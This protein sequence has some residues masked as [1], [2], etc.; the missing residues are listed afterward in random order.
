MLAQIKQLKAA[1]AQ[2]E[3][4]RAG[5]VRERS[6]LQGKL[7]TAQA[8]RAKLVG[9]RAKLQTGRNELTKARAKLVT[10]R[11][12][13]TKAR[14]EL[15]TGREELT[16]ARAELAAGREEL[17]AK[18]AELETTRTQMTEL[19]DGVPAAF[20]QAKANYL[21]EIDERAPRIEATFQSGLNG[22]FR[23]L[24]ILFAGACALT[25]GALLFVGRGP[26]QSTQP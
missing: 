20:E 8:Q 17:L 1:I 5:V 9:E 7:R 23:D 24:Y 19:K 25:L 21:A 6:A 10:G 3:G 11:A 14:G 4:Q 2:L 16:G 26:G 18:R 15:A 22:G 13:L 12:E